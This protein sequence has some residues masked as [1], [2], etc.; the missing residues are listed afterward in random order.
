MRVA[1]PSAR[2]PRRDRVENHAY[3]ACSFEPDN[4]ESGADLTWGAFPF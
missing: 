3:D 4:E 1:T 2:E